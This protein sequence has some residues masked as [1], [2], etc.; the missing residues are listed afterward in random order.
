MYRPDTRKRLDY[1][2]FVKLYKPYLKLWMMVARARADLQ[3][4]LQEPTGILRVLG[5]RS[6][7][8]IHHEPDRSRPVQVVDPLTGEVS[9]AYI[10]KD[11]MRC[12]KRKQIV[13]SPERTAALAEMDAEVAAILSEI[14][15]PPPLE[16]GFNMS[17]LWPTKIP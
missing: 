3:T 13:E 6:T 16:D 4:I 15:P 5:Y 10:V 1:K 17:S 8:P 9:M 14:A 7:I 11:G 12:I 2:L